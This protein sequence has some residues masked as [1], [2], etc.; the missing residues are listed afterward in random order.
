[1]I[2]RPVM[3]GK[4]QYFKNKEDFLELFNR[5]ESDSIVQDFN[6]V[7]CFAP[8][9]VL[10]KLKDSK[11]FAGDILL[12][13]GL[14]N[15]STFQ[16]YYY[17]GFNEFAEFL[18]L[19]GYGF[20]SLEAIDRIM[21]ADKKRYF[22]QA[23]YSDGMFADYTEKEVEDDKKYKHTPNYYRENGNIQTCFS[24]IRTPWLYEQI[25][26]LLQNC[27]ETTT[28][29]LIEDF[30]K[31]PKKMKVNLHTPEGLKL[32]R[33]YIFETLISLLSD[34]SKNFIKETV[35]PQIKEAG[36]T[37]ETYNFV[38]KE[39]SDQEDEYVFPPYKEK[40]DYGEPEQKLK[41]KKD[42]YRF[43]LPK[44]A[45]MVEKL[46]HDLYFPKNKFLSWEVMNHFT[47]EVYVKK[48][49]INKFI[50]E[51]IMDE[52]G[53]VF[54]L[55][56]ITLPRA[57]SY[58]SLTFKEYKLIKNWCEK[59]NIIIDYYN[60]WLD[61]FYETDKQREYRLIITEEKHV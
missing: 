58:K 24:F 60:S 43:L 22:A 51:L 4:K 19:W 20:R 2:E 59:K 34:C 55:D 39:L 15:N 5:I 16:S 29:Y 18:G 25:R 6:G 30:L 56:A 23:V 53:E 35:I 11:D 28:G 3:F 49:N 26:I 54:R 7:S 17:A 61:Q 45:G 10:K 12:L 41:W 46:N 42:G 27:S 33:E 57:W 8:E 48:G 13:C 37:K 32:K 1:M 36:F 21:N 14:E 44:T 50:L 47:V 9:G 31:H 40:V 38:I 52:T